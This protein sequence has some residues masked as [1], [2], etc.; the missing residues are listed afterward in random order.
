MT[1]VRPFPSRNDSRGAGRESG[2]EEQAVSEEA[3]RSEKRALEALVRIE[4]L[5]VVRA[6]L[7]RY[8][9]WRDRGGLDLTAVRRKRTAAGCPYASFTQRNPT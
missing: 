3:S 1:I 9:R 7:S 8:E 4:F 2:V 5:P 6:T